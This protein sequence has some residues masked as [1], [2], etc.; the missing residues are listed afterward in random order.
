MVKRMVALPHRVKVRIRKLRR[1]T[2]HAG[3]A[4]R[5]QIIL[6]AA[7][8]RSSREVSEAVGCHRSW[9]SR[10]VGA[11][12]EKGE[13]A[14]LDSR[15]DNGI[16]KVD[17]YFLTYLVGI[18]EVS[19]QE[20]D[21]PR[22]TWTQELLVLVM[23]DVTGVR[24]SVATMS[25]ALRQIRAR[26]GRPRAR[27][28]CPWRKHAKDRRL[29]AIRRMLRRLAPDE[30]AFYEDEVD[31]H[32]NPKIG[33]DWMNCGQQKDVMTPGKNEKRYLAGAMNVR[34]RDVTYVDAWR[35]T[36]HLFVALMHK[37]VKDHP[38]ARRIHLVLDNYRIHSSQLVQHAL[39]AFDGRIV[40]HFLPPYCPDHNAIERLWRAVHANVTRNHKCR[41]MEEL[42][43]NVFGYLMTYN[44]LAKH[45]ELPVAA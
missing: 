28:G 29:R 36:S 19:P 11:F 4:M 32:L 7:K 23:E 38:H 17:E 5:C 12:L 9:A 45:D 27:V 34:T 10:V 43:A 16:Q 1:Q 2:R 14:L 31:I 24:V 6:L 18:V 33:P 3:V 22:P 13:I 42:M 40:L 20:F 15:E 21:Y 39:L 30:E 8:G 44:A 35:K 25:R 41:C 26:L 37:L